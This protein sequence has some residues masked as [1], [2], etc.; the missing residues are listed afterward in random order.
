MKVCSNSFYRLICDEND[1]Y[2]DSILNILNTKTKHI[3][4]FFRIEKIPDS[5][6]VKIY[7]SVDS[8]KEYL[9]P[10]LQ[11]EEYFEWMIMSTHD[12]NIN[13]LSIDC[14]QKTKSHSDITLEEYLN[15]IIHEV[16]H[17]M[18]HILKGN[19]KT[20]NA[21]FHEAL[22][23]NLSGQDYNECDI[24][25]T[26]TE[27]KENFNKVEHQYSISYTLGKYLLENYSHDFIL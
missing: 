27:L 18:H 25:C 16:V 11:N 14:C 15:D 24:N 20:K 2:K 19:N 21:W 23:T 3:I 13:I 7:N 4:D 5:I 8:F 6:T 1:P 22:A 12:G 26:L 10:F 9:L 17:K